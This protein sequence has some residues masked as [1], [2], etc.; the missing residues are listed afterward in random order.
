MAAMSNSCEVGISALLRRIRCPRAS[1]RTER[2]SSVS[3]R[4][5]A[6][7][8]ADMAFGLLIRIHDARALPASLTAL[9]KGYWYEDRMVGVE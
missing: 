1:A 5:F 7:M 9:R 6:N 4:F 3:T 8:R 2:W